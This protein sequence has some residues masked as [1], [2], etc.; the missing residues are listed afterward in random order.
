MKKFTD[1]INHAYTLLEQESIDSENIQPED[2]P[3]APE[4]A[5]PTVTDQE[6]AM[7]E[8]IRQALLVN[9]DEIDS[10]ELDM[11]YT[12]VTSSNALAVNDVITSILGKSI[13]KTAE[14]EPS[15]H[16]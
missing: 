2:Q 13:D 10:D 1:K 8:K 5:E 4:P 7:I 11:I 12:P 14:I 15:G 3:V 9:R 6:V 16:Y